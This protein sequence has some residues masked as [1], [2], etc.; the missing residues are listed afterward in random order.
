MCELEM[1]ESSRRGSWPQEVCSWSLADIRPQHMLHLLRKVF[2]RIDV[3]MVV[4]KKAKLT[5]YWSSGPYMMT[6]LCILSSRAIQM[7]LHILKHA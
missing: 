1:T 6:V 3:K 4:R 7:L 2:R 5:Q